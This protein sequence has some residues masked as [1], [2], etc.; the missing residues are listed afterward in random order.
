M[1][2]LMNWLIQMLINSYFQ[3]LLSPWFVASS[4]T[5]PLRQTTVLLRRLRKLSLDLRRFMRRLETIQQRTLTYISI[6]LIFFKLYATSSTNIPSYSRVTASLQA[7][8]IKQQF[9]H[10]PILSWLHDCTMIN[11]FMISK[12]YTRK[13]LEKKDRKLT[14]SYKLHSSTPTRGSLSETATRKRQ[15]MGP[16]QRRSQNMKTAHTFE[17]C[18]VFGIISK[19]SVLWTKFLH[20]CFIQLINVMRFIQIWVFRRI[21][22]IFRSV[23]IMEFRR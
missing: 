16:E 19:F 18:L 23:R 22:L 5:N 13:L 17:I 15:E 8:M 20:K 7:A 6:H 4:H 3:D 2:W 10:S 21:K 11:S 14:I 1:N 12:R 9:K